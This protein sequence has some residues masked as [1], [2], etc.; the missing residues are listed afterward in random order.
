MDPVMPT[1]FIP[2][3]PVSSEAIPEHRPNRALGILSLLAVVSV[4]AVAASYGAVYLYEKQLAV[5]KAKTVILINEARDSIGTDFLS[6]M[7]QLSD[8]ITAVKLVLAQHIVVTPIFAALE[9]TTLR[10]IQFKNFGY[11]FTT[12]QTTNQT[13]VRVTLTGVA[14]S[15]ATIALQSDALTQS[16]LIKNPV[17][18]NLTIDEKT[19][20]VNFKLVFTVDP[21]AL[22]F[23]S[24]IANIGQTVPID[25]GGVPVTSSIQ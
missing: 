18:S 25:E 2:K 14:K 19:N 20:A 5:Q 12:D 1:S 3:R 16:T 21:T 7:K 17:F 10:S 22:S 11:E 24:F 23:Q 15:Y 8:R 9:Q 4:L 13:V 6:D